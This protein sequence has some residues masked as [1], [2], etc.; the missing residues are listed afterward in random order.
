MDSLAQELINEIINNVPRKD[1]HVT[2]LVAKH[3]R[4]PSQQRNFKFVLFESD[5]VTRWEV[6][7]PQDPL[8][9]P[10]YV[11]H[12]RFK[13]LP[14]LKPGTLSR[15]LGAF[16]SM[17]SLDLEN[18]RLPPPEELTVPVSL[19]EFG[20]RITRL[21]FVLAGESIRVIASSILSFPNL[22]ELVFANVHF[23]PDESPSIVPEIGRRSLLESIVV[24]GSVE[25]TY[26]VIPLWKVAPRRLSLGLCANGMDLI[27]RNASKTVVELTLTGMQLLQDCDK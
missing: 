7:I 18:P 13:H 17:T 15:V 1:M 23:R 26:N 4:R 12:V 21:T 24:L 27:L 20:Q 22:K 6:N 9:I 2:S 11:R 8:G 5:S 25:F 16:T 14:S 10:S 19:G 3:C